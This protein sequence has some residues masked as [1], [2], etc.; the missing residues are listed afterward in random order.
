MNRMIVC[1][2]FVAAFAAGCVQRTAH[3]QSA[4]GAVYDGTSSGSN[5]GDFEKI[6]AAQAYGIATAAT[7]RAV[8]TGAEVRRADVE[9]RGVDGQNA[10]AYAAGMAR[11]SS[12]EACNEYLE[13][14]RQLKGWLAYRCNRVADQS[15]VLEFASQTGGWMPM[16]GVPYGSA[17]TLGASAAWSG[18]FAMSGGA[19]FAP[20]SAWRREVDTRLDHIDGRQHATETAMTAHVR[21][22]KGK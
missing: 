22:G 21:H 9:T 19:G 8:R 18:A 16:L 7:D 11:V 5:D 2:A 1:A 13:E 15:F 6:E 4:D 10:V 20:G 12:L 17:D 3:V 14:A